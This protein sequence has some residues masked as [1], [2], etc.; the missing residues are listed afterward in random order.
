MERDH[1]RPFERAVLRLADTGMSTAEIAWRF[2]RSPGHIDRVLGLS[3]LPRQRSTPGPGGGG[4]TLRPVER[5]VL[6]ARGNGVE[7]AE[8]AARMRRTPGHVMR[9]EHYAS[10]KLAQG[11]TS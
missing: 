8:I 3:R 11:A 1:L 6:R 5:C 10:Y 2:R 9:V 4:G 7:H